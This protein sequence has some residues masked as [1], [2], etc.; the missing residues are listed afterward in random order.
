VPD[1]SSKR[2]LVLKEFTRTINQYT[3]HGYEYGEKKL[4]TI[5]CFHGL[6]GDARSFLYLAEHFKGKF[7]LILIDQPGHGMSDPLV[8]EEEY[9]FSSL[10]KKLYR[11]I[12][13]KASESFYI[14]GHSWGGDLRYI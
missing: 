3:F 2:G 1:T 7:H 11:L 5:V 8:S 13:E 6:T 4:P 14:I 12:E 10:V 9:H